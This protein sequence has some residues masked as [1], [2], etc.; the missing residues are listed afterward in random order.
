[1]M[2]VRNPEARLVGTV[3]GTLDTLQIFSSRF[4]ISAWSLRLGG[5]TVL[6]R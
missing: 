2:F 4:R 5:S 6:E 3:S 1:M